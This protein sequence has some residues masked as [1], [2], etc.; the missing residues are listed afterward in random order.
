[1][2]RFETFLENGINH[3]SAEDAQTTGD[4]EGESARPFA[5][6]VESHNGAKDGTDREVAPDTVEKMKDVLVT[7]RGVMKMF[8]DR[9]IF[10]VKADDAVIF[11]EEDQEGEE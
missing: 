10:E 7:L 6:D 3:L 11:S 8:G 5:L 4:D 9:D 1:M 2:E